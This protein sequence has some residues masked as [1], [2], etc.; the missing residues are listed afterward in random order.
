[1]ADT[2][3]A[4]AWK[5]VQVRYQE[6]TGNNAWGE[7][8]PVAARYLLAWEAPDGFRCHRSW[9]THYQAAKDAR[10]TFEIH[11]DDKLVIALDLQ[12]GEPLEWEIVQVPRLRLK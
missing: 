11:P 8:D 2:T 9:P 6:L 10:E 7:Q 5:P 12:T 3:K 4:Q 1:M